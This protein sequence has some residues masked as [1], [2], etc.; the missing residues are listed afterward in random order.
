MSHV[1]DINSTR[2]QQI[3]VEYLTATG[4]AFAITPQGEQVFLNKRLVETMGVDAGD[5]Y[6]AFLVQNYPDKR[7]AIPWRA[8]RVE[9]AENKLDLGHVAI[10]SD[11]Q[12]I[13]EYMKGF[14]T[15]VAFTVAELADELSMPYDTVED[16]CEKHKDIFTQQS[17]F[18]LQLGYK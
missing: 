2:K 17:A 12:N 14:E 1:F 11:L 6:D 8:M 18:S 4:S 16:L 7:E 13:I 10:D 5:I 3:L 15:G 9:P